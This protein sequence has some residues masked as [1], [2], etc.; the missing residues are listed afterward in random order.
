MTVLFT[1]IG[2]PHPGNQAEALK[3]AKA[4]Q[5]AVNKTY[6]LS[7]EVYVRFGGPVGQV[8][9]VESFENL[10]ALEKMKTAAIQDTIAGKIPTAPA[11]IFSTIEEHAWLM[12]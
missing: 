8:V 12:A 9:M 3:Y 2:T 5:E 11:G 10:A 7:A 4:R 1:R 6:A